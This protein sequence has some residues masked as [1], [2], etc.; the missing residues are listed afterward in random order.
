MKKKVLLACFALVFAH[1]AL[2]QYPE[3]PVKLVMPFPPGGTVDVLTRLVASE[4]E[5]MLGKP[6]VLE[7]KPG[8]GGTIATDAVAHA[9]PDG[10]TILVATPNHTINPALRH[11]LPFDTARDFVA[12]TLYANIPELL[13]AHPSVPF[14]DVPG[15]LKY[16]KANPGKLSYS[17][18][19]IGTLPHITMELLLRTAGVQVT[20]VPYKGAAPAF[21]D[22]L[23][24]VVQLKY[25]TYATSAPMLASG[26]LKV[27]AT[28]GRKRLPQL[29]DVATVAEAGFPNYEGYLWIGALAPRGT[30]R[31]AV[32]ALANALAKAAASPKVTAR[33]QADGVEVPPAG[34]DAFS[35]VIEEE[36]KLWPRVVREANIKVGD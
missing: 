14:N 18:A 32:S 26:K 16:A 28:A 6:L 11:K 35:R 33:F 15:M 1:A 22:L 13:V 30:P 7:Y 10:Y 27:L 34:P 19:G 12:V 21:T 36:L 23:A 9:A 5:R 31:E 29:P 4:A 25:D 17:S 20:H 8:A 3:R 2:A 24:G